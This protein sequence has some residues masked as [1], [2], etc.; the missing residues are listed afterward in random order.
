[1][2]A[3]AAQETDQLRSGRLALLGVAFVV[4]TA[5]LVGVAW[6]FVRSPVPALR[7]PAQPSALEHGLFDRASG[8]DDSRAAGER[9]LERYEW[10][11]RAAHVVRIPID[12]AIDA[13][14]ADPALIV[15]GPFHE[16]S[17]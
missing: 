12:R 2:T 1:M 8:G 14:V 4:L 15:R 13:V 3:P 7:A 16:A 5:A 11:D 10:V 17:R 9:R 6:R